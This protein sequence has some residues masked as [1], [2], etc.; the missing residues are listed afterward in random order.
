[1]KSLLIAVSMLSVLGFTSCDE[2]ATINI[3]GPKIDIT[4]AYS[5]LRSTNAT[6]WVEIATDTVF[7]E[8]IDAYLSKDSAN[9]AKADAVKSATI[10]DGEL[11]V[12][13]GNFNFDGVDS[14]KIS[15]RIVNS[16]QV[17]NLVI[18]APKGTSKDTIFFSDIKFEK[19]LAL[20]LIGK[21]KVVGM[22]AKFNP[23]LVN[24]FQPGAIYNFKASTRLAVLTSAAGDLISGF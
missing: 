14:V 8:N 21:D 13:G 1:M 10:M 4:F 18:G 7:G 6:D 19:E 9:A 5:D 12:T 24:C 2:N 23:L 15:Y 22:Y 16:T 20:D 3:D 17:I 11:I